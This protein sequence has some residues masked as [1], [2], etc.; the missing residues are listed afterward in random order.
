M[1]SLINSDTFSD[2]CFLVQKKR[3]LAHKAILVAR[4]DYFKAMFL[5]NMKEAS[6]VMYN[7]HVPASLIII[8]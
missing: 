6:L 3:V 7:R 1:A 4:C 5:N 2:V 8:G